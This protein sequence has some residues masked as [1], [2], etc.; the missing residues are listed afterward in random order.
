[1]PV[2]Y[3]HQSDRNLGMAVDRSHMDDRITRKLALDERAPYCIV[4]QGLLDPSWADELGGMRVEHTRPAGE[5]PMTTIIGEVL[6]QAAL[7]GILN[8]VYNL[9]YPLISVSYLGEG[10]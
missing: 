4:L 5:P 6:D 9:G 3:Y 10:S 2:Y 8:L 7:A 1:M